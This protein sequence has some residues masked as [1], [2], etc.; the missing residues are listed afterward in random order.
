[1]KDYGICDDYFMVL[2]VS[3]KNVHHYSPFLTIPR[4]QKQGS[5]S[6]PVTGYRFPPMELCPENMP[7]LAPQ[8]G[9]LLMA[10]PGVFCQ[11]WHYLLIFLLW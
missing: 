1:M 5:P 9:K 6:P 4:S 11:S 8:K 7:S 3:I 10:F 2:I